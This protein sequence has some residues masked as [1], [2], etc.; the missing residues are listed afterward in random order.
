MKLV[1]IYMRLKSN[2]VYVHW[3]KDL[4]LSQIAHGSRGWIYALFLLRII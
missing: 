3:K 1:I 4:L 2:Q